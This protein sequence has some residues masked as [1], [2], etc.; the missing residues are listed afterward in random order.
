MRREIDSL[1]SRGVYPI[2]DTH[3]AVN[4][5]KKL[6]PSSED[7][8]SAMKKVGY[9]TSLEVLKD[10]QELKPIP[11]ILTMLVLCGKGKNGGDSLLVADYIMRAMP[12]AK[13][14][15][16][17]ASE[18]NELDPLTEKALK[19]VEERVS[20][21]EWAKDSSQSTLDALIKNKFGNT[22]TINICIDGLLGLGFKSPLKGAISHLV[23]LINDSEKI[24]VRVSIDVPTG[25][26]ELEIVDEL[27]FK[28]DFCYLA[29]IP[30]QAL[31]K[32]N[33][34]LARVRLI[35]IG[36]M[37]GISD[38]EGECDQYYLNS[39]CLDVI[40]KLRP[41]NVE[42][43]VF[44]HLFI[45]GGSGLMPGAL[46]MSVKAAIQSGA[47]LVTAFAPGSILSSL[48]AQAP[49]AMWIPLPETNFGTVSS[50]AAD[51][52]LSHIHH[53]TAIVA[54][55]GLGRSRDTEMMIQEIIQKTNVPILLDADALVPR[56]L[57]IIQKGKHT[58]KQIVLTPHFGEFL[59]MSKLM[60]FTFDSKSLIK[61]V[62]NIGATV[63]L[64]GAM[65]R[66]CNGEKIYIN[67][68]GGP[69][70][71]RGGSGDILA[72]IIGAQ[73]AQGYSDIA[74]ASALGVLIHGIAGE[75]L[76]RNRGQIMVRTTEVLDYL[77]QV[78][79]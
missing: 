52:V 57:E 36:L 25:V 72:G 19:E 75:H 74:L 3:Q 32:R 18:R 53:A 59:R 27:Y 35:D 39:N 65:T 16:L 37:E 40:R 44:G 43:R 38:L 69:V 45:V 17:L 24:D 61:M 78:L 62:K 67:T 26:S 33:S 23:S 58:S 21:H 34:A 22:G 15:V 70:F 11:E 6:L 55:P 54:G 68:R 76:A 4:L 8:W 13:V 28:A 46:L 77:P 47:G 66:I 64:K 50:R 60:N 10:Y 73:M 79:R 29:G 48:S 49:E 41:V 9:K 12:R 63:V 20:V 1:I 51:V 56:I 2:L 71:S 14:A 31:F 30:K 7:E 42:K 5:E